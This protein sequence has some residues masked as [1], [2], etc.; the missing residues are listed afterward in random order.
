NRLIFMQHIRIDH[1]GFTKLNY[2]RKRTVQHLQKQ[3]LCWLAQSL[4]L[5]I[6]QPSF[7]KTNVHKRT[8]E[9][10]CELL[11]PISNDSIPH[12]SGGIKLPPIRCDRQTRIMLKLEK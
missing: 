11:D 6:N 1:G 3:N 9:H 2:F 8:L 4:C 5:P 7:I 10:S 12:R